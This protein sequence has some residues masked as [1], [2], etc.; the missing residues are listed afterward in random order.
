MLASINAFELKTDELNFRA[1]PLTCAQGIRIAESPTT[2]PRVANKSWSAIPA[3]ATS[4]TDPP[5]LRCLARDAYQMGEGAGQPSGGGVG[6]T[7]LTAV[8]QSLGTASAVPVGTV[9]PFV[10]QPESAA[11]SGSEL[12]STTI[13]LAGTPYL[14]DKS[15]CEEVCCAA[16]AVRAWTTSSTCP[17][18][19]TLTSRARWKAMKAAAPSPTSSAVSMSTQPT[20]FRNA[21]TLTLNA[22]TLARGFDTCCSPRGRWLGFVREDLD[23][24]SERFERVCEHCYVD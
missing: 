9:S 23:G 11:A 5:R 12:S 20:F 15:A 18:T 3:R 2:R 7:G 17:G 4:W 10:A 19:T 21:A 13:G 8:V 22:L 24:R 14:K 1:Q 16:I 6:D